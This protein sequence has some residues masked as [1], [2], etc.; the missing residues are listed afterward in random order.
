MEYKNKRSFT[1][2]KADFMPVFKRQRAALGKP[3]LKDYRAVACQQG[4]GRFSWQ[5]AAS[6]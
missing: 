5:A 1:F 4:L 2:W 3:E 6:A